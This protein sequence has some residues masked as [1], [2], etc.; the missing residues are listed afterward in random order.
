[1]VKFYEHLLLYR[2]YREVLKKGNRK[3]FSKCIDSRKI[4]LLE[5]D[6]KGYIVKR[7]TWGMRIGD[8]GAILKDRLFG[9]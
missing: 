9:Y 1:M 5:K 6:A 3:K 8:S 4:F 7:L 2:Q